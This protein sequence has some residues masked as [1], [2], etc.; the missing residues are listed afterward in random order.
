MA[1]QNVI[2]LTKK[3]HTMD[4]Y[5]DS[6]INGIPCSEDWQSV[7]PIITISTNLVALLA[8]RPSHSHPWTLHPPHSNPSTTRVQHHRLHRQHIRQHYFDHK[9][10]C[11]RVTKCNTI[12]HH[13]LPQPPN[14]PLHQLHS[15]DKHSRISL[16]RQ[17]RKLLVLMHHPGTMVFRHRQERQVPL[18]E[19]PSCKEIQLLPELKGLE[20]VYQ[21]VQRVGPQ[22]FYCD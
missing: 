2:P 20:S 11:H 7:K 18:A 14:I 4:V 8:L 9:R 10:Q 12:I 5:P 13:N 6:Q 21:H 15:I 1:I 22:S 16:P 17:T 3:F 19:A